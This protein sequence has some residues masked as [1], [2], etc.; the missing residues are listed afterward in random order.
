ME[1]PKLR[2]FV[3]HDNDS[4]VFRVING[5][6]TEN[7]G[8]DIID[9]DENDGDVTDLCGNI[10]NK[11]D[12]CDVFV[13]DF[14]QKIFPSSNGDIRIFNPNVAIE[15][16]YV[17]CH[18][19]REEGELQKRYFPIISPL[20]EGE[21]PIQY[22]PSMLRGEKCMC[23]MH[24]EDGVDL[25]QLKQQILTVKKEQVMGR[26]FTGVEVDNFSRFFGTKETDGDYVM[27]FTMYKDDIL[28]VLSIN[29]IFTVFC[30]GGVPYSV[31]DIDFSIVREFDRY[32]TFPVS[33][34]RTIVAPNFYQRVVEEFERTKE[35][36]VINFST[37]RLD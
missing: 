12:I 7:D 5:I 8:I 6:F 13:V 11:I 24:T 28:K 20:K 21:D 17:L 33:T 16:G 37:K 26:V 29:D 22:L 35:S 30:H 4:S 9:T 19:S 31:R 27:Y 14:T 25:E 23:I 34:S 3:A 36:S 1:F 18:N 15:L 32:Q 2:V 10:F